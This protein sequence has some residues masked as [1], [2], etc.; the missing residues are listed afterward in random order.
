MLFRYE[1]KISR[2]YKQNE[3][4]QQQQARRFSSN[5]LTKEFSI[6]NENAFSILNQNK[7]KKYLNQKNY[8]VFGHHPIS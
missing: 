7:E 5:I 4:F 3:R 1:I 2:K 8:I 6:A